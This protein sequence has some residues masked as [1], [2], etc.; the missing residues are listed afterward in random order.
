M[1]SLGLR[2]RLRSGLGFHGA[3]E[4]SVILGGVGGLSK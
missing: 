4:A 1:L 2:L 3:S